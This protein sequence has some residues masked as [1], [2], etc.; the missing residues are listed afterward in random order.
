MS[1]HN[2]LNQRNYLT[3][4]SYFNS[5]PSQGSFQMEMHMHLL[6]LFSIIYNNG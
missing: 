1:L 3:L 2:V 5:V 4:V 6:C